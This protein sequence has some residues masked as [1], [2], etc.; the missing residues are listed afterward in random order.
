MPTQKLLKLASYLTKKSNQLTFDFAKW[1]EPKDM[2]VYWEEDYGT[3]VGQLRSRGKGSKPVRTSEIVEAKFIDPSSGEINSNLMVA[4]RSGSVYVLGKHKWEGRGWGAYE[5]QK[6]NKDKRELLSLVKEEPKKETQDEG[7]EVIE[8]G[9]EDI[10]EVASNK[11][12]KM[13]C[14]AWYLSTKNQ[15]TK[16]G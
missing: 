15:S 8:L 13:L 10:I 7:Q 14:L 2:L 3:I 12:N 4:T 1:D 16:I 9:D 11:A 5:T 6:A